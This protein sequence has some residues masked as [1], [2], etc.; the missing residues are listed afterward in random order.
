[1]VEKARIF[2]NSKIEAQIIESTEPHVATMLGHQLGKVH[3]NTW[4]KCRFETALKAN[5]E[6]FTQH[7]ELGDYLRSTNNAIL[8]EANPHDLVWSI[9]MSAEDKKAKT[10]PRWKGQNLLGFTLMA[11]RHQL[12]EPNHT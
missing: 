7:I 9:G 10:P 4:K 1:M 5:L 6:K 3:E 11:A 12:S 8:A 2:K